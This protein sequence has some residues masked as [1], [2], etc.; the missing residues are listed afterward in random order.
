MDE[1]TSE[2]RG[3]L[4][5]TDGA[6]A[7]LVAQVVERFGAAAP[8][9]GVG[10]P[11]V[12]EVDD[13]VKSLGVARFDDPRRMLLD[14]RAA[15]WL[16]ASEQDVTRE[17]LE[18]AASRGVALLCL[19]PA[20]PGA[21]GLGIDLAGWKPRAADP[22]PHEARL[23]MGPAMLESPGYLA[24]AEPLEAV[25]EARSIHIEADARPGDAALSVLLIDA[26]RTALH[27]GPMPEAI[28]ASA[29]PPAAPNLAVARLTGV[30][31]AHAR[32][33]GRGAVTLVV[34]DRSPRFQRRLVVVGSEGRLELTDRAYRL[35]DAKGQ[36]L[37]DPTDDSN[38]TKSS[39]VAKAAA[40]SAEPDSDPAPHAEV[41]D[42]LA[43]Q[44]RRLLERRSKP[45]PYFETSAWARAL[46]CAE[47]CVLSARTQSAERPETLLR[48]AGFDAAA[49]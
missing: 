46:A 14:T 15:T 17:H 1:P 43:M 36:L 41:A 33:P 45:A 5:W 30:L 42:L 39:G 37:D 47:A 4:V 22:P 12:G 38:T 18:L 11:R 20:A 26:W 7:E 8:I 48:V 28:D 31:H 19:I 9:V 29:D 3:A 32:L 25:G 27:F 49:G 10:G 13:L 35:W 34:R 21:G 23:R 44:W 40:R 16:L 24:A 6:S 2:P